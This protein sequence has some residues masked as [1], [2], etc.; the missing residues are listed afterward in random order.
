M[1]PEVGTKNS[2]LLPNTPM[3]VL[4]SPITVWLMVVG[5]LGSPSVKPLS[6][7]VDMSIVPQTLLRLSNTRLSTAAKPAPC[8]APASPPCS[9]LSQR[10]VSPLPSF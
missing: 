10:K 5:L 2:Q 1:G 8:T 9:S 6:R 4:T 3:K 7:P